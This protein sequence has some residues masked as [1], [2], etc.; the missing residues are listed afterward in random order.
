MTE[1]KQ[2]RNSIVSDVELDQFL[3]PVRR[4]NEKTGATARKQSNRIKSC[5]YDQWNKYDPG[6]LR[7]FLTYHFV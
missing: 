6:N 4:T 2:Q 3:P 7:G 5:D 1:V